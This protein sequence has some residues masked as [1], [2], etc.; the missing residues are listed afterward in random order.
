MSSSPKTKN[1]VV[2]EVKPPFFCNLVSAATDADELRTTQLSLGS[3]LRT[4]VTS[5]CNQAETFRYLTDRLENYQCIDEMLSELIKNAASA[6]DP[7]VIRNI[8]N[9]ILFG[10]VTRREVLDREGERNFVNESF[11]SYVARPTEA[12]DDLSL[13]D[14][15]YSFA[16]LNEFLSKAVYYRQD[17]E[18]M[19]KQPEDG[20]PIQP[21]RSLSIAA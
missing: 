7:E 16:T 13:D 15:A 11:A 17:V 6:D 14:H 5:E 20:N 4:Y 10:Y 2:N 8:A 18:Y 3:W 21:L 1:A 9:N 12:P 19:K